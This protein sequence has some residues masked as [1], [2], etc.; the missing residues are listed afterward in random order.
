MLKIIIV[1]G[2]IGLNQSNIDKCTQKFKKDGIKQVKQI[3]V[4]Q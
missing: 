4:D 1:V 3:F 2:K